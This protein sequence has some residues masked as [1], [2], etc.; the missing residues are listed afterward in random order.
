MPHSYK[1]SAESAKRQFSED[2]K[3]M[4]INILALD[5]ESHTLIFKKTRMGQVIWFQFDGFLARETLGNNRFYNLIS[6]IDYFDI[7]LYELAV[8]N[9]L[10]QADIQAIQLELFNAA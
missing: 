3:E 8:G 10:I 7:S 9:E 1:A 6:V 4:E 5:S 2:L